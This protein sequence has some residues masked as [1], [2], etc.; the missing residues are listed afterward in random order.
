M[1]LKVE[2]TNFGFILSDDYQKYVFNRTKQATSKVDYY[3]KQVKPIESY[4]SGMFKQK[5]NSYLGK[6]K[7]NKRVKL[8]IDNGFCTL[9]IS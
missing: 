6:T 1:R 7:D 9:F 3:L 5:D 4:I 8:S 2:Q